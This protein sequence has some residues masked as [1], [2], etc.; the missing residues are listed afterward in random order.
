MG[1][2]SAHGQV[3]A[4]EHVPGTED[5][6][7]DGHVGLGAGVGLDIGIFRIVELAEAVDGDLFDLVHHLAAAIVALAGITLRVLVGA[8]GAHGGH[9][10]VGDVVF[11]SD[12]L[13]AG[14]LAVFFFLDQIEDL[15]V[16]FHI[17]SVCLSQSGFRSHKDRFF[18]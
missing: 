5:G 13:E 4:H 8:D 6:H 12:Q 9:D 2:V 17:V 3:Q 1:E 16:L 7:R 11:R 15:E 18:S 10:L 14:G